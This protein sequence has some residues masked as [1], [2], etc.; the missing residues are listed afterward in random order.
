MVAKA[1]LVLGPGDTGLLVSRSTEKSVTLRIHPISE[2]RG[3]KRHYPAH[4]RQV[5]HEDVAF[6]LRVLY[7]THPHVDRLDE[8]IP[9]VQGLE[10][11]ESYKVG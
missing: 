11:A 1:I 6:G 10:A 8:K 7:C 4:K 9:R 3:S 2:P 5:R